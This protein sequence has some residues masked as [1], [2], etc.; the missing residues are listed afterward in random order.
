MRF[1]AHLALALALWTPP[2]HASAGGGKVLVFSS[3]ARPAGLPEPV[4]RITSPDVVIAPGDVL[5][6]DVQVASPRAQELGVELVFRDGNRIDA[7][8][9]PAAGPWTHVRIPLSA[10][11][12]KRL[13]HVDLVA[14]GQLW[15]RCLYRVDEIV[16]THARGEPLVLFRDEL[17]AAA[18]L[19][20]EDA[21]YAGVAVADESAEFDAVH[22]SVAGLSLP[23]SWCAYDLKGVRRTAARTTADDEFAPRGL[24]FADPGVPLRCAEL[25]DTPTFPSA[26]QR[27]GFEP[28]D[29]GRFYTVWL[30]V[31]STVAEDIATRA[32][33][34]GGGGERRVIDF[35]VPGRASN[36]TA[37]DAF[38][39]IELPVAA[40]FAIQ[41]F[42]FPNEPRL[43]VHA[44]SVQW[45]KQGAV[46]STF[47]LACLS[48]ASRHSRTLAD[49]TKVL[50]ARYVRNRAY[51]ALFVDLVDEDAPERA[52]FDAFVSGDDATLS[53]T[54]T[55]RIAAHKKIGA[56]LQSLR[57]TFE[58]P[59][60]TSGVDPKLQADRIGAG[61]EALLR[62]VGTSAPPRAQFDGDL[63]YL[64]QLP[65]LLASVGVESVILDD[66]RDVT[67][68]RAPD[69]SSVLAVR[70][71]AV[72]DEAQ[73]FDPRPW[74][75]WVKGASS[76][77]GTPEVFVSRSVAGSAR[78]D[79]VP[80]LAELMRT[81]VAPRVRGA[82][83][84]QFALDG[85]KRLGSRIADFV[86]ADLRA[87]DS[88]QLPSE[89]EL[90]L[91][92]RRAESALTIAEIFAALAR[93]DG[94]ASS[95]TEFDGLWSKLVSRTADDSK[96]IAELVVARTQSLL[97]DELEVL[98]RAA[99]TT[100]EGTPLVAFNP[101][102]MPRKVLLEVE[103]A[104]A[105]MRDSEGH[106][107]PSQT[108]ARG[109]KIFEV[110]VPSL[111]Y[112]VLHALNANGADDARAAAP[113]A[114]E[115]CTA[116]NDALSFTL[117]PKTG[118][119]TSLMLLPE[120]SELLSAPAEIVGEELQLDSAQFVERGP[121]R[122]VARVERSSAR[123]H[124]VE[125]YTLA[126]HAKRLDVRVIVETKATDLALR[127]RF[128]LLHI[129][130]KVFA[131]VPFGS[132]LMQRP[133]DSSLLRYRS[134]D[135][136]D[137]NDGKG[138]A[139]AFLSDDAAT[140]GLESGSL[141]I[142]LL[143]PG[144]NDASRETTFALLPHM[145]GWRRAG[146][147]QEALDFTRPVQWVVTSAHDGARPPRGSFVSALRLTASGTLAEGRES[148]LVL[149]SLQATSDGQGWT[150]RVAETF[151][152]NG[153]VR[154]EFDRPVFQAQRVDLRGRVLGEL[155][156]NERRVELP[157]GA[158]RIETLRVRLRP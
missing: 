80:L 101:L 16:I 95:Q 2:L 41:S 87:L 76:A 131:S 153:Q 135:W 111:G 127:A 42:E 119:L 26:G 25:G 113:L 39:L 123:A 98:A 52:L 37:K 84:A 112:S 10:S 29:G 58:K 35:A 158:H 157:I 38:T 96:S 11:A 61:G 150:L 1:P 145:N 82:T 64:R 125:E 12:G 72:F 71:F 44:I 124:V 136:L 89:R 20:R 43:S 93:A 144:A 126:A 69:G 91:D 81:D 23:P 21:A 57:I 94:L 132:A 4:V 85:V 79:D 67:R 143:A 48:H 8:S 27:I 152:T 151:G 65:Q 3:A 50:L 142:D 156:T 116:R 110:D 133:F 148:G 88:A 53:A 147:A 54:L 97:A 129:G 5:E 100:G 134:L 77:T 155:K 55:E 149:S 118:A 139:L 40:E 59:A 60:P 34:F 32:A 33:V 30:A 70:P 51:G 75:G 15:D 19:V 7:A 31:S 102:P 117:D 105:S 13:A 78:K 109:T 146:V 22:A 141:S 17:G 45:R 18:T 103:T 106:V 46:D 63:A 114:V 14:R 49:M 137:A 122:I 154:L 99:T 6:Y 115:G 121:L 24:L 74:H 92:G 107:V 62:A 128:P 140:C 90:A 83:A 66:S 104:S 130:P 138:A 28:I 120:K 47:R 86:P 36:V 56:A 73:S 108:S 68:W 9:A